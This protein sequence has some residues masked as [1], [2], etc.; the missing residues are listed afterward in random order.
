MMKRMK[1]MA[2]MAKAIPERV[3]KGGSSVYSTGCQKLAAYA[4]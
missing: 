4:A 1:L 2:I 3:N